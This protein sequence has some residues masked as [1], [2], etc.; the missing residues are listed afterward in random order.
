MFY[1]D[2]SE[3]QKDEL[4]S[5]VDENQIIQP[6]NDLMRKFPIMPYEGVVDWLARIPLEKKKKK[7]RQGRN[8]AS[9]RRDKTSKEENKFTKFDTDNTCLN[10][11]SDEMT[12]DYTS[13]DLICSNCGVIQEE[14]GL[15]FSNLIPT[16][17]HKNGKGSKRYQRIVHFSQ[18]SAQLL[19]NDPKIRKV[20]WT[21]IC[22]ELAEVLLNRPEEM[23][24]FGKKS[25]S[26]IIAKYPN[27]LPRRLSANWIQVRRRLNEEMGLELTVPPVLEKEEETI[28]WKNVK[29]RYACIATAFENTLCK[30]TRETTKK[31]KNIERTNI[32]NVNYIV[33]Q[34]LR[35]EDEVYFQ[36]YGIFFPQ[37]TSKDQPHQNNNRWKILVKYCSSQFSTYSCPKTEKTFH[38]TWKYIPMTTE[39]ILKFCVYFDVEQQQVKPK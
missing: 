12:E 23:E 30:K 3:E 29:A 36:K 8:F 21:I 32:Y 19:G 18:R 38:F 4:D 13:G 7:G 5:L 39:E 24:F 20:F 10:C 17:R 25:L 2:W 26:R 14:K 28:L 37:L 33:L 27:E 11:L 9:R 6:K 34:L 35:L 16:V 22:R 1:N 15:G 31:T